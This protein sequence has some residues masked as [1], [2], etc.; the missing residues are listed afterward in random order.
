MS[1]LHCVAKLKI[2]RGKP[3]ESKRLSA[4]ARNWCALKIWNLQSKFFERYRGSQASLT[5]LE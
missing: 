4:N 3:D 5:S 2:H 1:E